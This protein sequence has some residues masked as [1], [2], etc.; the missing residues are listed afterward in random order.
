MARFDAHIWLPKF[1][2]VIFYDW[3]FL[4]VCIT[5]MQQNLLFS[6]LILDSV[7]SDYVV[8]YGDNL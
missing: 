2:S 6:T 3:P 5:I 7:F 8:F 4:H 1:L